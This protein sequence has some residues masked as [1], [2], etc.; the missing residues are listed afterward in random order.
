MITNCPLPRSEHAEFL[1]SSLSRLHAAFI[2]CS[3]FLISRV[4]PTS[5]RYNTHMPSSIE[6]TYRTH[7]IMRFLKHASSSEFPGVSQYTNALNGVFFFKRYVY[8]KG[9]DRVMRNTVIHLVMMVPAHARLLYVGLTYF[10]KF[11]GSSLLPPSR[12]TLSRSREREIIVVILCD[13]PSYFP[14]PFAIHTLTR[15]T[16]SIIDTLTIKHSKPI[17][18]CR[19]RGIGR[20]LP[21]TGISLRL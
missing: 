15:V 21:S 1:F 7:C 20:R 16:D 4:S 9:P 8:M 6:R 2:V 11:N 18:P 19:V 12:S 14:K 3:L 10:Y 13:Q 5:L 17:R